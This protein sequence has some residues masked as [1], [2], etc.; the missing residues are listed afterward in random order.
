[1]H[2][3]YDASILVAP[4][5]KMR[6]IGAYVGL[7]LGLVPEGGL[8][9]DGIPF[10]PGP[11]SPPPVTERPLELGAV[12]KA[13]LIRL[14]DLPGGRLYSYANGVSDDGRV[15]VGMSISARG[16]EAFKWTRK[17]GMSALPTAAGVSPREGPNGTKTWSSAS[18]ASADGSV[19]TGT[20]HFGQDVSRVIR[21]AKQDGKDLGSLGS[22]KQSSLSSMSADGS[23]IV[24]TSGNSTFLW[25][26]KAG[27]KVVPALTSGGIVSGNGKVVASY[28]GSNAILWTIG[29]PTTVIGPSPTRRYV[30]SL[31]AVSREGSVVVG[32]YEAYYDQGGR[33]YTTN[34]PF[35]WTAKAG[36]VE[37]PLL[38]DSELSSAGHN[39][40]A[41][42]AEGKVVVGETA[43][44][45]RRG[46]QP[47][48]WDDRNGTRDLRDLLSDLGASTAAWESMSPTG[49]SANGKVIVGGGTLK[50]QNVQGWVVILP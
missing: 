28:K 41:M 20:A 37:L 1:M 33:R 26:T 3:I 14:G 23:I 31:C 10:A 45:G 36:M 24:G 35:R 2:N 50:N 5:I 6:V 11:I 30:P 21:W 25:T 40:S 18:L 12:A 8:T 48:I 4:E 16:S 29:G 13:E 32:T 27:L 46:S 34:R 49:I 19:I 43:C 22:S 42:S 15:V 17:E 7:I 39:A 9:R 38:I 47:W 44:R